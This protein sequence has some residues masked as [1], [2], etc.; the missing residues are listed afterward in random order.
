MWEWDGGVAICGK[1][2]HGFRLTC[3][4]DM[5]A[6]AWMMVKRTESELCK[7]EENCLLGCVLGWHSNQVDF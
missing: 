3:G 6:C 4:Y 5:M 2:L 7:S 1:Y